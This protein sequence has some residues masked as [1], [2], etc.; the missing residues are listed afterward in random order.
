MR[1]ARTGP[2]LLALG[3]C[4]ACRGSGYTPP[5]APVVMNGDADRGERVILRHRCGDCHDIP[6]VRGARGVIGMPLERF[7]L[8]TYIAGEVPNTPENLV[9]WI[10]DP[11]QIEP[12]TAMPNLGLDEREARDAAA[13]LYTLR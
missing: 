5:T 13:Y 11:E 6:G 9:R 2:V 7:A 12:H 1:L 10:R 8:R 4:G 3:L